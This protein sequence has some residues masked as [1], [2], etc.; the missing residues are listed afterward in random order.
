MDPRD[1]CRNLFP[2]MKVFMV[3]RNDCSFCGEG[4][5][6]EPVTCVCGSP[7]KGPGTQGR[8]GDCPAHRYKQCN[9]LKSYQLS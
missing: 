4:Q 8:L 1:G 9:L 5:P 7:W 6:E 2:N 3:L